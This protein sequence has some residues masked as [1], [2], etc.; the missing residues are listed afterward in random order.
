MTKRQL[1]RDHC[2]N[3]LGNYVRQARKT[4]EL[5]GDIECNGPSVDR[6]LAILEQIQAEDEVQGSYLLLRQQLFD[7]LNQTEFQQG[8]GEA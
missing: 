5:L 1:L 2:L 6:L 8:R 3:A 4:C 7:V